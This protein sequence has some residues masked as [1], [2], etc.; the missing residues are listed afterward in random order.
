MLKNIITL[1]FK[2]IYIYVIYNEQIINKVK[3]NFFFYYY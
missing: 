3:K 2:Y 1:K